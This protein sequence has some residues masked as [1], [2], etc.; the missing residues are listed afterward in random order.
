[1]KILILG[2]SGLIGHTLL[3]ELSEFF[4]V[5]GIL[6]NSLNH[7]NTQF[8]SKYKVI[9]NVNVL[10]NVIIEKIFTE[11]KPEFVL[12][13]AGITKRKINTVDIIDAININAC[14]PH[15]LAALSQKKGFRVIHFS[16]DCVFNGKDGNYTEES[17]TNAEDVYGKTKALGEIIS[18]PNCL[19]I[20]SSFIGQ[21]LFDKTELLDWFLTQEGKKIMGFKNTLY[22]GISTSFMARVVKLIICDFPSLNGLYQLATE[23]PISK[24]D[25]LHKAKYAFD[26][27]VEIIPDVTNVHCPTLDAKKLR[28]EI[29]LTIPPWDEMMQELA[30]NKSLYTYN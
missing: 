7:Y 3:R 11:I 16:T 18:Y 2:A 1:M 13:C 9:E 28:N 17:P 26:V 4:E 27:K 22:S 23:T 30:S 25:L 14:F 12:N 20:R 6:H 15:R 19:T 24:Y 21:E 8:F 5:Y 10:N 29:N